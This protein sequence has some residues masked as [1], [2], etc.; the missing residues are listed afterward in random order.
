ML[1]LI[2]FYLLCL[3]KLNQVCLIFNFLFL[4]VE[5][6]VGRGARI[7][8]HHAHVW[9]SYLLLVTI[10]GRVKVLLVVQK[11]HLHRGAEVFELLFGVDYAFVADR[12]TPFSFIKK[13]ARGQ[14]GVDTLI[15]SLSSYVPVY[16]QRVTVVPIKAEKASVWICPNIVKLWLLIR[17]DFV[18]LSEVFLCTLVIGDELMFPLVV[19]RRCD[20]EN[21]ADIAWVIYKLLRVEI[22]EGKS[23]SEIFVIEVQLIVWWRGLI[24]KEHWDLL[25]TH[26]SNMWS[27]GNGVDQNNYCGNE[28]QNAAYIRFDRIVSSD[29]ETGHLS[30]KLVKLFHILHERV[31]KLWTFPSPFCQSSW[32][33]W[34]LPLNL[35]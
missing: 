23:Y 1:H 27:L 8:L 3:S 31:W 35:K 4:K 9:L 25:A 2:E 28:C 19:D 7:E 21:P 13:V 29:V 16:L 34:H 12:G 24:L 10:L 20:F 14:S 32:F 5:I 26:R 11:S 6:H 17:I 22:F 18:E 33:L 30:A 15:I